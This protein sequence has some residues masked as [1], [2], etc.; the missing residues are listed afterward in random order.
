MAKKVFEADYVIDFNKTLSALRKAKNEA[1]QFDD[2]MSSIGDRGNLNNL[3]KHFSNLDDKISELAGSTNKLMSA[4]GSG[5]QGGFLKSMDESFKQMSEIS[6]LT[7]TV[8][9][10]IANID[11]ASTNASKDIFNYAKQLNQLFDNIGLDKKIDLD[12][13]VGQGVEQQFKT[14]LSAT[15]NLNNKIEISLGNVGKLINGNEQ[16]SK[17]Q[18]GRIKEIE[19]ENEELIKQKELLEAAADQSKKIK[20]GEAPKF[21][22][23]LE[24]NESSVRKMME[25]FDSIAAKIKAM[26]AS[27]KDYY[28]TLLQLA[29]ASNK[30]KYAFSVVDKNEDLTSQFIKSGIY[31]KLSTS[32]N[33][34]GLVGRGIR[35]LNRDIDHNYFNIKNLEEGEEEVSL[36]ERIKQKI[37]ECIQKRKEYNN[38]VSDNDIDESA[39]SL[40]KSLK[41]L[42]K[43]SGAK[44]S[45]MDLNDI[46]DDM[47]KPGID[48]DYISKRFM[49]L[50]GVKIPEAA[51]KAK[52][53]IQKVVEVAKEVPA[54][55][56]KTSKL[57]EEVQTPAT[58]STKI[59][60][61]LPN[62]EGLKK[63]LFASD[64]Q[65]AQIQKLMVEYNAILELLKTAN[66][67]PKEIVSALKERA[68]AIRE[69]VKDVTP[70]DTTVDK[71]LQRTYG[72]TQGT[73]N[74]Y[75]NSKETSKLKLSDAERQGVT[76]ESRGKAV[77]IIYK[78]IAGEQILIQ[79][80]KE[81]KAVI[82]SKNNALKN[83]SDII[84]K[85]IAEGSKA[86]KFLYVDTNGGTSSDFVTGSEQGITK[87][88]RDGLLEQFGGAQ[89]FNATLHTHPEQI[90]APSGDNGD[91]EIFFKDFDKFKK[92][93][94]LAGEQLAE[95]DFSSLTREQI[96]KIKDAFIS[97][98]SD[99]DPMDF[100]SL[101]MKDLSTSSLDISKELQD[102]MK[103]NL[104]NLIPDKIKSNIGNEK[105]I[106][107]AIASYIEKVCLFIKNGDV[108]SLSHENFMDALDN[109][110][111]DTLSSYP[112]NVKK[113]LRSNLSSHTSDAFDEI[114]GV[115]RALSN[116]FQ[117]ALQDAFIE[118]INE[119]GLDSSKIFKLYNT[120]DF[121]FKTFKPKTPSSKE[122][123][124]NN[125]ESDNKQGEELHRKTAVA[126]EEEIKATKDNI[127]ATEENKNTIAKEISSYEELCEV[128]ERYNQLVLKSH[129]EG[130]SLSESESKELSGINDRF[131]ATKGV[132]NNPDKY[133]DHAIAT[134]RLSGLLGQYDVN[135]LSQYLGIKIPEDEQKAKIALEEFKALQDEILGKAAFAEG[136]SMDGEAIGKYTERIDSAKA[137]LEEFAK[138]GLLTAEQIKEANNIYETTTRD[139]ES[140]TKLNN[141]HYKFLED[142]SYGNYESGYDQ[143]YNDAYNNAR[144]DVDSEIESLK[145]QLNSA[146]Q[147]LSRKQ[148][149]SPNAMAT[150]NQM[151]TEAQ[152]IEVL[153]SEVN[154]V[155]E[156]VNK[157]TEAFEKE[158]EVVQSTI[159]KEV[160]E[161]NKLK[162]AVDS[163]TIAVQEKS[164]ALAQVQQP[165]KNTQKTD[166]EN[167][168]ALSENSLSVI[169]NKSQDQSSAGNN[170]NR[171]STVLSER[172]KTAYTSLVKYGT[173]IQKDGR[174]TEEFNEK[175][176]ALSESLSKIATSEGLTIW[177]QQFQQL[178]NS[179]A[180]GKNFVSPDLT[181][182]RQQLADIKSSLKSDYGKLNIDPLN[183]QDGLRGVKAQ[184]DELIVK[185]ESYSKESKILSQEEIESLEQEALA[186][187]NVAKEYLKVNNVKKSKNN[188]VFG[189][190]TLENAKG[191]Y[192][193][194]VQQASQLDNSE[195]VN[196]AIQN[197]TNALNTL[198]AKQKEFANAENMSDEVLSQ[199][200][201]NFK[202]ASLEC[203]SYAVALDKIIKKSAA[204]N[205]QA[206]NIFSVSEGSDLKTINGRKQALNDYVD[207]V[208][209][210][211]VVSKEFKASANEMFFSIKNGDGTITEMSAKFNAAQNSIG[212]F[213]KRI[214]KTSSFI[215]GIFN[216]LKGQFQTLI[217]YYTGSM[218]IW[219]A[220]SMVR[221][222]FNDVKEIDAALTELKKVTDET[223]K[224]YQNFLNDMSKVA[225][226]VGS[227]TADLT[228]SA[229]DWARLG[230]SIK[231]AGELAKNTAILMNVSEFEDVGTATE[232]L[233]SSLQ[234]FNYNASNSIEIVDKLNIIGN[235]FAISTDGIAEGLK[236]S[237]S[238]LVA[239]GNSLEQSIAM[240]AAGNKVVQDPE[241]L[242]NA[243]KV[244]SMRIRGTKTE[245]EEAGE[246]TEGMIEN[247]SKLRDKVMALTNVN[248][249]GGVD[250]L[251][252]DGSFRATYDI[253]L[254]IAKVW[255]QINKADPK[256]QAALL[257][258]LAGKTRGSQLAA[259]LQNPQ[260]LEAAYNMAQNSDG[261]ALKENEKYLNS[262]Q[263]KLDKLTNASQ[264]FWNHLLD[265]ST[266]KTGID[267][268]RE[269][270]E[271]IDKLGIGWT[272][273]IGIIAKYSFDKLLKTPISSGI[274]S[275][276]DFINTARGVTTVLTSFKGEKLMEFLGGKIEATTI[277]EI[278]QALGV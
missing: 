189:E 254:D 253:L 203:N 15:Q 46:L 72:I 217:K 106:N 148:T 118:S 242:G 141:D 156:A 238:T 90:A 258:V 191:K 184:Y 237:A 275:L 43:M 117:Q 239:A 220:I 221:E 196:I 33:T 48:E 130:K 197:Y 24:I 267:L 136:G 75:Q 160:E 126:I 190:S 88:Q 208:Y 116:K 11:L 263:G 222:G 69:V 49:D 245:L 2:I 147:E 58:Q 257:E 264:V 91:L 74:K 268:L 169:E 228:N 5:V 145:E 218:L 87:K 198:E 235:N 79:K 182:Q 227:T 201:S 50:L 4:L 94:I 172:I 68:N 200:K 158:L 62:S 110:A 108:G 45:S 155:T 215:G 260:D 14:L 276:K 131:A 6:K 103:S 93:F 152:S 176:I 59:S 99:I 16:L 168:L 229:A 195:I 1:S 89:K 54:V 51:D 36:Y 35:N 234:A 107:E 73:V 140:K 150:E 139:L 109:M 119:I 78:Q 34:N 71:L 114:S 8:V 32:G 57:K 144:A 164:D 251:A 124:T 12:S 26:D 102:W 181:S 9:S 249:N 60:D 165:I 13:L 225:G 273:L 241:T 125:F 19:Q 111:I 204:F 63:G 262:I 52:E 134:D 256:N 167:H 159:P 193:H 173:E 170:F 86:E 70:I 20:K 67:Q 81:E 205:S 104:F 41:S 153:S 187:K 97:K 266:V 83:S 101:L 64:D 248:G 129:T 149:N 154:G 18:R 23:E 226:V 92:N 207:S 216:G 171:M 244:L 272:A 162:S 3:I 243:L 21:F 223:D 233:I 202:Q 80:E 76:D 122:E 133:V 142:N 55:E 177:N 255:D 214:K 192:Q 10:G 44:M 163:V 246:S 231:E 211:S 259:I 271:L 232:A 174:A 100:D 37:E 61:I 175:I 278:T 199:K 180:A 137:K 31:E 138:Q 30:V 247:T 230:Y 212:S 183:V 252:D 17:I 120:K 219:R 85:I 39:L 224:T 132:L 29:V 40:E 123:S 213:E 236:R 206:L 42:I 146:R 27:S 28:G 84:E 56:Q 178:K 240:L 22:K 179:I 128:V 82:D 96:E 115:K 265:S 166:S 47:G 274:T 269:F 209:G 95:I 250:I 127:N 112:E 66:K 270:I 188:A 53:S 185:L 277:N 151:S 38:A 25:D 143:G 121:D 7:Q 161:L 261:S 77:D 113:G 157:K 105:I 98:E 135:S 186:I 210:A 65:K 194:L